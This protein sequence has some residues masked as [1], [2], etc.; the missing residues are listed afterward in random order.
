MNMIHSVKEVSAKYL[1]SLLG[2]TEYKI[3]DVRPVDAYNGWRLK[4]E[5]RGGHIPHSKSLPVKWLNYVDWIEIVRYKNILPEDTVIV[6]G[7]DGADADHW[8]CLD[9]ESH[10]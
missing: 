8:W 6:Y 10:F 2:K 7:Y 9:R 1:L 3:I 5:T 4:N